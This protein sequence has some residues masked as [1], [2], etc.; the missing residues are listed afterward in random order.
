VVARLLLIAMAVLLVRGAG[1]ADVVQVTGTTKGSFDSPT[2]GECPQA[3]LESLTYTCGGFDVVTDDDG[4]AGV[5]GATDN[6]GTFALST[7]PFA[8]TG[9]F[10]L[11]VPISQPSGST[12][13][14]T[15]LR[16]RM[17]V[18]AAG[19]GGVTLTN[20]SGPMDFTFPTEGG[21]I[22]TFTLSVNSLTLT[23][24]QSAPLTGYIDGAQGVPQTVPE[25]LDLTLLGLGPLAIVIG[26]R[27]RRTA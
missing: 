7:A 14:S 6:L 16:L 18:N 22:G 27:W 23:P 2:V 24:G 15:T 3:T 11:F 25:P 19:G 4:F 10:Y 26:R 12:A 9:Y 13:G 17:S 21:G 8:Y 5:G 1:W 20:N